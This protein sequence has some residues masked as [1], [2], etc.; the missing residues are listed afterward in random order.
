MMKVVAYSIQAFEKEFLIKA[1]QK[2]HDITLISNRLTEETVGFAA[3]KDAVVVFTNDDVSKT[4]IEKLAAFG[5]KFIATRSVGTDHIDKLA[6]ANNGIKVANVPMYSPEA[7][8]EHTIALTLALSRHLAVANRHSRHFNFRLDELVGFNLFGKTVGIIGLGHIGLVTAKLFSAFGCRVLGYDIEPVTDIAINL[9]TLDEL[10]MQSDI[11]S[12][13]APLTD[14]TRHIINDATIALMKDGVMLINTSRGGLIDTV[15]VADALFAGKIGY[16]GLDVYEN[17]KGLF[18]EDH[19]HDEHKDALLTK[20]LSHPNVLVTPHQG[21]LTREALQE[22]AAKT[23]SNLDLWQQEKCVGNACVC[24]K[25]CRV[26]NKDVLK[27]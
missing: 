13:H 9:V 5:V 1:N 10:L 24:A 17:E 2:K 14:E 19:E 15:H 6:A 18:F 4:I 21:F 3:G 20:L 7:I 8:A 16:L 25:N 12:L 22:I 27:N 26:I 23:I 11:V